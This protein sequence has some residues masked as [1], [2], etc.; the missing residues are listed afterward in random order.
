MRPFLYSLFVVSCLSLLLWAR[1]TST[2]ARERGGDSAATLPKQC[3]PGKTSTEALGWRWKPNTHVRLY[4]LKSNFSGT[5]A[6]AL[7]R[8]VNNWNNAL[9]KIDSRIVFI[10]GGER[11]S[12]V[13]DDASITVM[14]G[15]PKGKERLGEIK[16]YSMSNGVNRMVVTISPVVTDLNALTSLMAHEIGHSLGLADCYGCRRGTTT[17]AA[18]KDDN[19]GNDV[20]EPSEC[21]KYVVAS[22]YRS[23]TGVQ[24]QLVRTERK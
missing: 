4:Y 20:Y 12:V 2:I 11:E 13:E 16:F 24:A 21:D 3:R 1:P 9:R 22:G 8:A 7:S 15:I 17:M 18:F 23:E 6:E 14:R 10:N 5:E 19:K